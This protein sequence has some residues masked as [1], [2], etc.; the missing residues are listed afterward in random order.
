[1]ISIGNIRRECARHHL[2]TT[3]PPTETC[4]EITF[5]FLY[6]Q[7]ISQRLPYLAGLLPLPSSL[8]SDYPELEDPY[9]DIVPSCLKQ[10]AHSQYKA[11]LVLNAEA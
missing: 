10:A 5:T 9:V 11:V 7:T 3:S 4:R 2:R 1:M 8:W 6:F